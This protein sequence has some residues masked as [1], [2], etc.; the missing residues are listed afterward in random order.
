M[1]LTIL[2]S[3]TSTGV[4]VIQCPCPV[5]RSP[6][7][8]NRRLRASAWIQKEDK[9]IVIDT[10]TDFRAQALKAKIPRID[11]VLYTHPHADHV[12]GIDDLRC[13]NF[14][15]KSSIPVFG[16][17]WTCD[18]LKKKFSYIFSGLKPEGGVIPQI[19]LNLFD[20]QSPSLTIA[21]IEIQPISLSHGSKESVGYRI[22]SLAYVTD[23]SYIPPSSKERLLGLSVLVLD[24]VRLEP[25][26]THFNLD[27]ALET[28]SELKPKKTFLTHLGHE[29]DY[30]VWRKKLPKG[31][32][33]AYDGLVINAL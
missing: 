3:G 28:V 32:S 8:R 26:S 24:C 7:A 18:E 16:N 29:L 4:P 11:A 13:Y 15:Q 2:G 17:A 9:H 25:H 23:C 31:V 33:F 1:R 19:Q 21:G 22:D 10:S 12:H 30:S 27:R 14:I 6:H 20:A 5:C